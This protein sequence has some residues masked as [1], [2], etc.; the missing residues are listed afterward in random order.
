[1]GLLA[2][3]LERAGTYFYGT[4]NHRLMVNA[5]SFAFG[6]SIHQRFIHFNRLI[7][8]NTVSVG[9]NHTSTKLVQHLQCSLIA[10]QSQLT[11]KLHRR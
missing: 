4:G 5:T 10:S 6:T 3:G 9:P 11:L 7:C 2:I 8:V 1:M